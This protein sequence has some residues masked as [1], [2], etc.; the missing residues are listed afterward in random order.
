VNPPNE[1]L[2]RRYFDRVWQQGD[3]GAVVELLTEDFVDHDPPPGFGGDRAAHRDLVTSMTAA[4]GDR[5]HRIGALVSDRDLVA[6]R[7]ETEW[8]QTGPLFGLAADGRRLTLKGLD[9]YRVRDGRIAECWHCENMAD[10]L[11]QAA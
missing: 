1:D 6:V 3:A 2:V 4:M 10:V 7:H 8:V 9:M 5:Q 11:R